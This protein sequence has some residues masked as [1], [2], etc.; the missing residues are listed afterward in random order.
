[1]NLA[2]LAAATVAN[3]EVVQLSFQLLDSA[4]CG[5]K[6]LVEPIT[7]SN[8]MLL[9]LTEARFLSL[10]LFGETTA[11]AFLFFLERLGFSSAWRT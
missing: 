10:D 5:L 7:F 6:V 1:M 4:V 8:E 11:Q 2:A 3:L 9:P